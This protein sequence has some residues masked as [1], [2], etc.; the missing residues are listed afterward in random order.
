MRTIDYDFGALNE[1]FAEGLN[2][3]KLTSQQTRAIQR[4]LNKFFKDSRCTNVFYTVNLSKPFFG[5][6]VCP[7]LTGDI[8]EMLMGTENVRIYEYTIEIDSHLFNPVLGL[9]PKEITAM[10]LHEV[11][12]VVNDSTP[13]DNARRYLDEYMTKHNS[14]VIMTDSVHYRE[15]LAYALRDFVVKDRSIFYTADVDE[16]LADDF[17]R[18][19]GYGRYL[20]SGMQKILNN[21]SKLYQGQINDRFATFT[22]TLDLYK[23][24]QYRRIPAL[25]TLTKIKGLTGS[26]IE[27]AEIENLMRR[28]SQ[29]DDSALI[30]EAS[31][32][33]QMATKVKARMRKMRIDNM[34]S[35]EDDYYEFNMRI[36]NVEDEDDALWLM[37]QINT[38]ISLITDFIQSEDLSPS[39]KKQWQD[40]LDRF[41]RLRSDLSNTM[42]YKGKSYG[43]FVNYPD[44][45]ENRY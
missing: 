10:L 17:V 4:E 28:V 7:R 27:K 40:S 8:Y 3:G 22:W 20:E 23:H 41:H 21:N 30:Q 6:I 11:G 19:Y 31:P 33:H 15:I 34:K 24:M 42:T 12:H 26:R 32:F 38:R 14:T 1:I 36:R 18:A 29:I 37:R 44:I 16:V 5:M 45:Q 39:E 43:I 13:I 9:T 2:E 35:L 25:R